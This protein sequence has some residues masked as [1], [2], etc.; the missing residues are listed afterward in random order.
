MMYNYLEKNYQFRLNALRK[1]SPND[2]DLIADSEGSAATEAEQELTSTEVFR[3]VVHH[4]PTLVANMR[5]T[6][7][8]KQLVHLFPIVR[9]KGRGNVY[10]AVPPR[11]KKSSKRPLNH[12]CAQRHKRKSGKTSNACYTRKYQSFNV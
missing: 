1:R 2:D 11:H 4:H 12:D 3:N 9:R 8:V 6:E 7:C 5:R 10:R